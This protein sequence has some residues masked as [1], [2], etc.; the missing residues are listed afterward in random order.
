MTWLQQNVT[1]VTLKYDYTD[2]KL[3]LYNT[4]DGYEELIITANSAEDGNPVS[5]AYVIASGANGDKQT[6]THK[7][8]EWDIVAQLVAG[9][10][11]GTWRDGVEVRYSTKTD[12][13]TEAWLEDEVYYTYCLVTTV[14]VVRLLRCC[15]WDKLVQRIKQLLDYN[16][17]LTEKI[18]EHI[19]WTIN[20]KAERY[21]TGTNTAVMGGATIS[22]RYH[23]DNSIDFYDEDN[24]QILFTKNVDG[25]GNPIHLFMSFSSGADYAVYMEE[26]L[27][28]NRLREIGLLRLIIIMV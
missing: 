13:R 26:T 8:F 25:D 24:E 21:L 17:Q 6:I 14:S 3:K 19:G 20:D 7:E 9:G 18:H 15:N 1:V 23:I 11:G 2:Y 10:E 12:S 5:L 27:P 22:F 4:T 28:L 16:V